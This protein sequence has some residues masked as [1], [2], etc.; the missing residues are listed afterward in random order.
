MTGGTRCAEKEISPSYLPDIR[1]SRNM[2]HA[3]RPFRWRQARSRWTIEAFRPDL[4]SLKCL[5]FIQQ[6]CISIFRCPKNITFPSPSFY[7]AFNNTIE[8]RR[9]KKRQNTIVQTKFPLVVW[10]G[11]QTR[12]MHKGPEFNKERTPQISVRKYYEDGRVNS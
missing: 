6:I 7:L 8:N 12:V 10:G 11:G 1:H 5:H 2:T 3:A 9:Q 4:K